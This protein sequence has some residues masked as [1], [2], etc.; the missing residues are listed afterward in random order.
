MKETRVVEKKFNDRIV[1]TVVVRQE[2][3]SYPLTVYQD[4]IKMNQETQYWTVGS[5]SSS[6]MFSDQIL[7][8][9]KEIQFEKLS[10][11]LIHKSQA[12]RLWSISSWCS[13]HSKRGFWAHRGE[14]CTSFVPLGQG[15]SYLGRV[16]KEIILS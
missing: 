8:C 6:E 12:L 2:K 14:Q 16:T 7:Y 9:V 5:H 11:S 13:P 10:R 15:T 1:V 3:F 4:K